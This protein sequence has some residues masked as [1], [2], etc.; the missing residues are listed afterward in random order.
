[1]HTDISTKW[2]LETTLVIHNKIIDTFFLWS[3]NIDTF[4]THLG[5][6][7]DSMLDVYF[8]FECIKIIIKKKNRSL[9][10]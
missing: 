5:H 9:S 7:S 1:M 8:H 2:S 10:Q 4:K 3:K 6:K